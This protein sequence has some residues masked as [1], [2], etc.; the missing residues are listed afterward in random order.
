MVY[1]YMV[2]NRSSELMF[3]MVT[4]SSEMMTRLN[5]NDEK[6]VIIAEASLDHGL[7]AYDKFE[8]LGFVRGLKYKNVE[9]V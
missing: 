3:Q 1:R 4:F 9:L 5:K 7:I 8:V 2:T 6:S